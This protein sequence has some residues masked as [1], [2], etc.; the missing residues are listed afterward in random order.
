MGCV[1]EIMPITPFFIIDT[2]MPGP[3]DICIRPLLE[4]MPM[5][6]AETEGK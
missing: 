2:S 4:F 1:A 5:P 6:E 3:I